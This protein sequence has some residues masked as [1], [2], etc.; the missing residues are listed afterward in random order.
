MCTVRTDDGTW[1]IE[2]Y[3]SWFRIMQMPS[4]SK[5]L[6]R[7]TVRIATRNAKTRGTLANCRWL[8]SRQRTSSTLRWALTSASGSRVPITS[9]TIQCSSTTCG[10]EKNTHHIVSRTFFYPKHST[11]AA[12]TWRCLMCSIKS[13]RDTSIAMTFATESLTL[14]VTKYS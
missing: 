2:E 12:R 4:G 10:K 13:L 8:P 7:I 1:I 9:P 14:S 5:R 11:I 6:P 3:Q